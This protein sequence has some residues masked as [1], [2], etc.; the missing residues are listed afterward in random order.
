MLVHFTIPVRFGTGSDEDPHP[1][2]PATT[3]KDWFDVEAA[4]VT[5]ARLHANE[6]IGIDTWCSTYP[7]GPEWDRY[8]SQYGT[9]RCVATL[10]ATTVICPRC[11]ETATGTPCMTA[12]S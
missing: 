1:L 10:T 7:D 12:A 8:R 5:Q 9:G 3:S 11:G 4:D 6:L 2:D